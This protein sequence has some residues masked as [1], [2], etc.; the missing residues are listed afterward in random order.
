MGRA[1]R[2]FAYF[3]ASVAAVA[4]WGALIRPS[5]LALGIVGIVLMAV[6]PLGV[7]VHAAYDAGKR[8]PD[9]VRA[10]PVW[11]V[12]AALAAL[13]GFWATRSL[14]AVGLRAFFI[15]AFK[16]PSAGVAPTLV[17]GD[18]IFTDKLTPHFRPPHRG[19]L[20]VFPFPL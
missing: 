20:I 8:A 7:Y 6:L 11:L 3:G 10:V 2:G 14:F 15:E 12:L 17:T 5:Y 4:A 13:A 9:R 19:E 18:Y 16:I 1:K